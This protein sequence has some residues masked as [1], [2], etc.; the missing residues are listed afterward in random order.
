M[1][2]RTND[3]IVIEVTGHEAVFLGQIPSLLDSVGAVQGDRGYSVLHRPL[4]LDDRNV[5]DELRDLVSQELDAQR[6][7]DRTVLERCI[8][9]GSSMTLDE[10]HGVLRSLNDARLV[11]AARA[12]VFE[13]GRAWEDRIDEDPALAAVAWL[14]Y[15]QTEL[16]RAL[17]ER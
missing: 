10:G 13:D 7:T 15:V 16:L 1:F 2:R 5:D 11:L 9:E 3:A 17:S 8:R 14:G 4:C 6:L 12:G